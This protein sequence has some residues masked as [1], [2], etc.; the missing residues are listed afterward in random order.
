MC[1]K[2]SKRLHQA[3]RRSREKDVPLVQKA[4]H[5]GRL[6]QREKSIYDFSK[7]FCIK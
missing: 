2:N 1:I 7:D 3:E 6:L 4:Q 5:A